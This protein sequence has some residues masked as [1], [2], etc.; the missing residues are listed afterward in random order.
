LLRNDGT[1]KRR[2]DTILGL[3]VVF[4]AVVFAASVLVTFLLGL[5]WALNG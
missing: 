3:L 2:T 4:G 1:K 5:L